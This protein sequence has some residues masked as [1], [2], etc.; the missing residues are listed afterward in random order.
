MHSA[1]I[2]V[3]LL[4][5]LAAFG[6]KG[7]ATQATHASE[8]FQTKY[9]CPKDRVTIKERPDLDPAEVLALEKPKV[10][11]D[12]VKGDAERLAKWNADQEKRMKEARAMFSA[13]SL[14]E[15]S[16]CGHDAIFGCARDEASCVQ[17]AF[18]PQAREQ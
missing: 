9:A 5:T 11:P 15:V 1:Y 10:P 4:F 14:F 7:Q 3:A 2:P 13:Y 8:A 12:D 16:G 6:C 18:R 17:A